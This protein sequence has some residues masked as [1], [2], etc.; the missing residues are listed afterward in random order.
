PPAG[1]RGPP[2]GRPPPRGA[3]GPDPDPELGASVHRRTGGNPFLVQQVGRL[4]AAPPQ[5]TAVPHGVRARTPR[6]R[7]T[8]GRPCVRLLEA[9]AVAGP[10]LRPAVL[11]R[12]SGRP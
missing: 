12:M 2:A 1:G 5:G 9:G 3:P 8:P 4:L 7:A 10:D 6:R 11:A